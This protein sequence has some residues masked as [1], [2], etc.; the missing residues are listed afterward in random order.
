MEMFQREQHQRD[1][2]ERE[3]PVGFETGKRASLASS[4]G[5]IFNGYFS[6]ERRWSFSKDTI[7]GA[8][9][10]QLFEATAIACAADAYPFQAPLEGKTGPMVRT[11]GREMLMLSSY[12][13]LGL[14]GDPR[15]MKRRSKR[16]VSMGRGLVDLG[17]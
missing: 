5:G 7:L 12:D 4:S 3:A 8:R 16:W 13:Y 10:R 1:R 9:G 17:C 15:I 11:E 6:T 14:I 2:E